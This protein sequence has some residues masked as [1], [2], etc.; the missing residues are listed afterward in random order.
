MLLTVY[1]LNEWTNERTNE[2]PTPFSLSDTFSLLRGMLIVTDDD[3]NGE[4]RATCRALLTSLIRSFLLSFRFHFVNSSLINRLASLKKI[5]KIILIFIMMIYLYL[6]LRSTWIYY[7]ELFMFIVMIYRCWLGAALAVLVVVSL[8]YV[9]S[10]C[11]CVGASISEWANCRFV[12]FCLSVCL[13]VFPA[14]R[15][16]CCDRTEQ[17]GHVDGQHQV[18]LSTLWSS[19]DRLSAVGAGPQHGTRYRA[20]PSHFTP[21]WFSW[22]SVWPVTSEYITAVA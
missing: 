6:S 18:V 13:S 19:R 9:W 8:V 12:S 10:D 5:K 1:L 7:N 14:G 4:P 2:R 3:D 22:N 17:T 15:C 11:R 21:D 16:C 20:V